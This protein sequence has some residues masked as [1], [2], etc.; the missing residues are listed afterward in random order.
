MRDVRAQMWW[1]VTLV[2]VRDSQRGDLVLSISQDVTARRASQEALLESETRLR[3]ML[4]QVPAIVWTTDENLRVKSC[5]G[6]GLEPLGMSPKVWLGK[7]VADVLGLAD[8]EALPLK[9]HRSALAGQSVN[10]EYAWK[11]WYFHSHV[12]PL[13]DAAG[14]IVGTLGLSLDISARVAAEDAVRSARDDLER[15]VAERTAE[16]DQVNHNLLLDI[17]K[18]ERVQQQLRESEE[19]F[20]IIA[21]TVPVAIVITRLSDGR[22]VYV[23]HRLIELF[24]V[25][26]HELVNRKSTDFYV[27][28]SERELLMQRLSETDTVLELELWL[29][30]P[31]SKRFLASGNYQLIKFD[32]EDC[33]L[34]GLVDLTRRVETEQALLAERRLL[35]RLL[36]LH[37][38]DRQLISYEIHDGIV[39][40]M[41][42]A[43]MFFES[44]RPAGLAADDPSQEPF[45]NGVRLLRGSIDEARRLINGLRPPVLEDEGVVAA[46][47]ALAS[48]MERD[49][50]LQIELVTDVKFNRLAPAL[51]M[52]IYRIVQEGL[53]NVWHHSRSAK[54]RVELMQRDDTIEIR[55]Q[56]WGI[57]F[58]PAK[59]GKR[60][61][62]LVGMRERARLLNG[63]AIIRSAPGEG[64]TLH[65]ELP[66]IDTLMPDAD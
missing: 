13:R 19:R 60:R 11:G 65:I 32:N 8:P 22:V 38:R 20:R 23:N 41:T 64:T 48:E 27:E 53:N 54:A 28:P 39:Q 61:Y 44:S 10:F 57:G 59:V 42:A 50:G 12:E 2:P 24:E 34:T 55:V 51:E 52:A 14:N 45:H 63:R 35:K 58:D 5:S 33:V 6:A 36:E 62:G 43:Q 40:D 30:S 17:A 56:D 25:E 49:A 7:S 66:L 18:R 47:E 29:Q 1:W 26:P 16:L 3:L 21:D 37:E 31:N 9:A 46:I 15:R 4:D